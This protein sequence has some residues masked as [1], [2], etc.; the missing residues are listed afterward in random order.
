MINKEFVNY[1]QALALKELRFDKECLA[2]YEPNDE[3]VQLIEALYSPSINGVKNL[4]APLYQQVFS[5]FREKYGLEHYIKWN[6]FYE[7]TPHNWIVRPL[8]K[9]EPIRPM[10]YSGMCETYREA[11]IACIDELINLVKIKEDE[12]LNI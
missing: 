8:W 3:S 9:N 5:W 1:K 11:E 12:E 10:G 4:T 6:K 7:E 2:E